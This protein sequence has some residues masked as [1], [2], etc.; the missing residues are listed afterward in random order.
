LKPTIMQ[1]LVDCALGLPD[2]EEGIAC[3][4]TAIESHTVK[5]KKKAF[6]FVRSTEARLK[7]AASLREAGRFATEEPT[8]Y[9]VGANGWVLIRFEGPADYPVDVLKR[10]VQESY[11][12]F[13]NS[14]VSA[15]KPRAPTRKL[16]KKSKK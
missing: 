11:S 12:L 10:W 4:G 7:L 3:A 16:K 14:K 15:S 13:A 8:R 1:A 9:S 5:T 2:T 6:L